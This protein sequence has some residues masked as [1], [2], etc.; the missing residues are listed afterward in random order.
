M[1]VDAER[2]SPALPNVIDERA[3][4]RRVIALLALGT[5]LAPWLAA[6]LLPSFAQP[7]SYHDFADQRTLWGIPHAAN[8]MSNVAF[9]AVGAWG[10]AAFVRGS[11]NFAAGSG[12]RKAWLVMFVGVALTGFG[13]AYYHLAPADS[14]LVWD[15]LPMALGFAGVV[16]GTLSDRAP[17]LGGPVLIAVT[18]T[19]LGSVAGW[20]VGGDLVPYLLMQASYVVAALLATALIGSPY[21]HGKWLIGA[22]ALYAGAIVCEQLDV[23]IDAALGGWVSGHTLK[24]L[25]AAAAAWLI[26]LMLMRRTM[27]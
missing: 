18:A 1:T 3:S 22:V 5:A 24:H 8:V 11:M 25:L 16:A 12:A 10:L 19:A 21:T 6:L 17:R 7:Q 14:T 15:R 20:A 2:G 13:S 26:G 27:A 23:P 9:V 4:T